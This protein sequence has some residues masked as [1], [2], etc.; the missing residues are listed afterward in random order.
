[1]SVHRQLYRLGILTVLGLSL[2][3]CSPAPQTSGV[4]G[5]IAEESIEAPT[6]SP[7]SAPAASL[8]PT[9][10]PSETPIPTPAWIAITAENL[11]KLQPVRDIGRHTQ[12]VLDVAVSP[13]GTRVATGSADG[14]IRLLDAQLGGLIETFS[15]HN[16]WVY[17]LD[18]SPD[19]ALLISGGRDRTVQLW[20]MKTLTR[21]TGAQTSGEPFRI[22]FAPDGTHFATAGYYSARGQVWSAPE[23][24]AVMELSGHDTRL[25]AVAY[26]P[27]GRWLATSDESGRILIRDAQSGEPV[28]GAREDDGEPITLAFSPDGEYLAVG[29][30][31][32]KASIWE[33]ETDQL[34]REWYP[35]SRQVWDMAWSAGSDV[36]I[37]GGADGVLRFWSPLEGDRL[38]SLTRHQAAIRGIALSLDGTTLVTGGEDA[39]TYVWRVTP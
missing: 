10:A 20:D 7:S 22:D 12:A 8:T 14:A 25:R 31:N 9:A 39:V 21:I 26:S 32:G 23:G 6:L 33:V 3:A 4:P 28:H 5:P 30:S 11:A 29:S 27:D 37:T 13:D 38:L 36:L 16:D 2:I 19:G 34:I 35:H 17:A 24:V 15:H 1:M 18:F